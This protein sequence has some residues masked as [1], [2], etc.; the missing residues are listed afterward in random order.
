MIF[1]YMYIFGALLLLTG[2]KMAAIILL[3]PHFCLSAVLATPT[4]LNASEKFNLHMMGCS[5]DIMIL[6]GLIMITGYDLSIS[7]PGSGA[8]R[9]EAV[10]KG[11]KT[12]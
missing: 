5:L 4:T 3:I 7:T 2:E 10:K 11:K 1:G 6:A 9:V 12:K 8:R